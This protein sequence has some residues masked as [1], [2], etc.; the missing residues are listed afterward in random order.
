MTMRKSAFVLA[1]FTV[2][3]LMYAQQNTPHQ[4]SGPSIEIAGVKLHLGMTKADVAERLVGNDIT[5]ISEKE[6]MVGTIG[7]VNFKDE[8]LISVDRSWSSHGVD[9]IDAVFGAVSVLNREGYSSCKVYADTLNRPGWKAEIVWIDCGQ[10]TVLIFKGEVGGV[11][12]QDV[13][14]RLGHSYEDSE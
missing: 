4:V 13:K 8:K 1:L 2:A 5:K 3:T 10:K 7:S 12:L 9:S 6:W 14:E 11:P